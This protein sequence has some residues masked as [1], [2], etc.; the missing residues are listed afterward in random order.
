MILEAEHLQ[1]LPL[2][3]FWEKMGE[4]TGSTLLLGLG[5]AG[6]GILVLFQYASV[7]FEVGRWRFRVNTFRVLG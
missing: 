1:P 3:D 6:E 5:P 2:S 4:A 7:Y